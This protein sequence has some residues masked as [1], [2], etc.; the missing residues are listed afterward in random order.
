MS[1]DKMDCQRKILSIH[2]LILLKYHP[3]INESILCNKKKIIY[4][5]ELHSLPGCKMS[6]VH[7]VSSQSGFFLWPDWIKM[8]KKINHYSV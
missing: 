8:N 6:R 4:T 3:P 7:H 5:Y 2:K 1:L